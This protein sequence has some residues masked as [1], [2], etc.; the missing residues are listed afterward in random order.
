MIHGLSWM[1]PDHPPLMGPCRPSQGHKICFPS[2]SAEAGK[3]GMRMAGT[4]AIEL[5]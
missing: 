1:V 2:V 5:S 4:E 3:S